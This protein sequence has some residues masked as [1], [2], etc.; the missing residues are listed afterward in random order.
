MRARQ[1]DRCVASIRLFALA[2][3]LGSWVTG[4]AVP[5]IETPYGTYTVYDRVAQYEWAVRR[6]LAPYLTAAGVDYPPAA[7]ALVGLK[8]ERRLEVY[9]GPAAD[10]L[11]FIRM[12]PVLA[13]SGTLGPKLVEGDGQ[14]PEG[15]YRISALNPNSRYHLSMQIDYPNGLDRWLAWLDGRRRLGGD[16]FIHGGTRSV[17][18]LAV[19]DRAAEDLFVLLARSGSEEVPVII[20]PVD[21]RRPLVNGARSMLSTPMRTAIYP[22]IQQA[23]DGLPP[24]EARVDR[25]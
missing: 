17:G 14:V 16:I 19:G 5:P 18:C 6:R 23:L 4:W 15:L 8:S 3:A 7:V 11:R 25:H 21:F 10:D 20:S 24:Y 9:A 1:S 13:A 22:R 2:G 12:Y